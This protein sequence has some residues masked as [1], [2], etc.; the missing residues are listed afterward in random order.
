[1]IGLNQK[2]DIITVTTGTNDYGEMVETFTTGATGVASRWIS[3][4]ATEREMVATEL[5]AQ[6]D[7][8]TKKVLMATGATLSRFDRLYWNGD[9]HKV[10]AVV[11][12]DE[13]DHHLE[14]WVSKLEG[15][16]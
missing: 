14:V 11:N 10:L 2:C 13:A 9:Y 15:V 8:T 12:P 6:F 16:S 4:K 1:M 5:G 3:G 7:L